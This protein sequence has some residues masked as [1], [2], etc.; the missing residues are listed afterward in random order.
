MRVRARDDF[1]LVLTDNDPLYDAIS[2]GLDYFVFEVMVNNIRVVDDRGDPYGYP[3]WM[4]TFSD[5]RIPPGWKMRI[6]DRVRS[7]GL[8]DL[9]FHLQPGFVYPG[10]WEDY[11]FSN[12][13]ECAEAACH[14]AVLDG[15]NTAFESGDEEDQKVILKATR[16]LEAS[17]A[18]RLARRRIR[19]DGPELA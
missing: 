3:I 13:D 9:D 12:G 18:A 4:F 5:Y 7:S 11:F 16:A 1:R 8:E 17:I 19:A 14:R 6:S 2:A 15:L 10:F